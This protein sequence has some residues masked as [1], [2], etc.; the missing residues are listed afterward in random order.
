MKDDYGI[1]PMFKYDETQDRYYTSISD[2]SSQILVPTTCKDPDMIGAFIECMSEVSYKTV[3]PAWYEM[4]MKG[5]YLRDNESCQMF[6][7]ITKSVWYDFAVINTSALG[8]PVFVT[9]GAEQRREG[10]FAS[11][12]KKK[13]KLL[14]KKLEQ[15]LDIYQKH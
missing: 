15:L 13:E 11:Y 2:N 6:D 7:I 3:T 1:L 9:R 8:D 10:N 14:T 12:W 4:A 5:K